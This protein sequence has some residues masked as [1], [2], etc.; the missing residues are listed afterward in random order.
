MLIRYGSYNKFRQDS[1]WLNEFN[2]GNDNIIVVSIVVPVDQQ[3]K[4]NGGWPK[5]SN[6]KRSTAM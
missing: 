6:N 3:P 1:K 2:S 4:S 5:I